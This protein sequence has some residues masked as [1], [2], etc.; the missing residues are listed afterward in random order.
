[1]SDALRDPA[2]PECNGANSNAGVDTI[3]AFLARLRFVPRHSLVLQLCN[4]G[5]QSPDLL[6][7]VIDVHLCLCWRATMRGHRDTVGC[8]VPQSFHAP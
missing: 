8:F 7:W 6:L 3:R 2:A 5:P 1:M 4:L